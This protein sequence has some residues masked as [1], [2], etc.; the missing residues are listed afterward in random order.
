MSIGL[1]NCPITE[2]IHPGEFPDVGHGH[3]LR[4]AHT[5]L[6]YR[7]GNISELFDKSMQDFCVAHARRKPIENV[8][9]SG[10]DF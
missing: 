9:P 3:R 4:I 8:V 1:Q 10:F 7:I 5:F 2:I 6:R